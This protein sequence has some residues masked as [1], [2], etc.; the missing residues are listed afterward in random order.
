MFMS[1]SELGAGPLHAGYGLRGIFETAN[2]E[3]LSQRLPATKTDSS[4]GL[5][6]RLAISLQQRQRFIVD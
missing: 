5:I 2:L 3:S 6:L 4:V 1:A